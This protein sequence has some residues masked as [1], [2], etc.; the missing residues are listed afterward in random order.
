MKNSVP[1]LSMRVN[2]SRILP[3]VPPDRESFVRKAQNCATGGDGP[4]V[5][6]GRQI[7][8]IQPAPELGRFPGPGEHPRGAKTEKGIW[9]RPIALT[10]QDAHGLLQ[11]RI[12]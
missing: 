2:P 8:S 4:L 12:L 11:R 7:L 6:R 9:D 10:D 3:I 1:L 5:D